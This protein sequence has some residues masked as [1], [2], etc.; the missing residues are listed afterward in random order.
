MGQTDWCAW[1]HKYDAPDSWLARR[2]SFVQHRIREVLDADTGE[3]KA[4]SI[5]A[6]QGRDLIGALVDHP[7]R[8]DVTAQLVELDERNVEFANQAAR[9]AGLDRVVT[10]V[11][12][13][14]L[15]DSYCGAAPAELILICGVFGHLSAADGAA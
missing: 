2:L 14:G 12:D 15:A 7:R 5:C 13:A 6:G 11:G 9:S 10:V 8:G 3:L 4:V 1:H